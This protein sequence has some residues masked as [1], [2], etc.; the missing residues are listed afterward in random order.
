[1]EKTL[2]YQAL[3]QMYSLKDWIVTRFRLDE[4]KFEVI[5]GIVNVGYFNFLSKTHVKQN[6]L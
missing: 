2:L 1:M 5:L 4:L 3:N 6:K